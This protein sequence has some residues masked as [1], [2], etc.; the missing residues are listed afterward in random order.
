MFSQLRST[1]RDKRPADETETRKL[2]H[3]A[4]QAY[5]MQYDEKRWFLHEQPE[6]ALSWDDSEMIALQRLPGV[7]TV[8]GPMCAWDVDVGEAQSARDP[9]LYKRTKWV[10]NSLRLAKLLDR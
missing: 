10:T 8:S 4:V 2:L 1:S 6:G 7:F 3:T 9:G 5:R